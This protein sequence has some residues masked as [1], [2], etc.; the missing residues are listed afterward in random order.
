MFKNLIEKKMKGIELTQ[1]EYYEAIDKFI[2]LFGMEQTNEEIY[3]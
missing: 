3:Y 2:S 1:T